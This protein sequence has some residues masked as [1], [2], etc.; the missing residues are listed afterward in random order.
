MVFMVPGM[1]HPSEPGSF[2]DR[3]VEDVEAN[4]VKE[5]VEDFRV[6]QVVEFSFILC[7]ENRIMTF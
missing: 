6:I 4:E 5:A 2:F 7:F 3:A 1:I